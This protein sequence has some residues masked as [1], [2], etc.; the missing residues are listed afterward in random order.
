MLAKVLKFLIILLEIATRIAK[1]MTGRRHEKERDRIDDDPVGWMRE[2]FGV[3]DDA[4]A[5]EDLP[6]DAAADDDDDDG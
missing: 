4:G 3:R 2:H 6:D 1:K 5:D